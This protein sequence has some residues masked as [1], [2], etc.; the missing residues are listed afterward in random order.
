MAVTQGPGLVIQGRDL[1]GSHTGLYV[2]SCMFMYLHSPA[3]KS[4][5]DQ[6]KK[7]VVDQTKKAAVDQA[8]RDV[9]KDVIVSHL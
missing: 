9:L 6:A 4:A 8:F 3:E 5:G 7:A 1:D 2:K